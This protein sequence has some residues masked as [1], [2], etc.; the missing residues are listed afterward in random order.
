MRKILIL[1]VAVLL[2]SS[3][4]SFQNKAEE[5]Y[6]FF[7]DSLIKNAPVSDKAK[8]KDN[9]IV[10]A[11]DSVYV[12]SFDIFWE[13]YSGT[14]SRK[15]E[16][17]VYALSAQGQYY[18]LC[19]QST[20]FEPHTKYTDRALMDTEKDKMRAKTLWSIAV[21]VGDERK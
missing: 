17:Y 14:Q 12:R 11:D 16:Y 4:K 19:K 1:S 8:I 2:I 15:S 5:R 20:W 10:Y 6:E 9:G 7:L 13:T 21:S 3:C 18:E